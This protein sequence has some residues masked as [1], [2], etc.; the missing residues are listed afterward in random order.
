MR[1]NMGK[2]LLVFGISFFLGRYA[3]RDFFNA[4]SLVGGKTDFVE[5]VFNLQADFFKPPF[6]GF[7]RNVIG[8][9]YFAD[10]FGKGNRNHHLI[11][12][13]AND[14]GA[15]DAAR[16][17]KNRFAAFLGEVNG[18]FAQFHAWTLRSVGNNADGG[19]IPQGFEQIP[20]RADRVAVAGTADGAQSAFF[21]KTGNQTA[22]LV[23]GDQ[24]VERPLF[25]P[26]VG[27]EHGASVPADENNAAFFPPAVIEF[28]DAFGFPAGRSAD[29]ACIK[30]K[31][32]SDEAGNDSGFKK[33]FESLF[34]YF[35]FGHSVS[36]RNAELTVR[37]F[38]GVG[39]RN[40]DGFVFGNDD[41][42][43]TD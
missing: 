24:R 8:A 28:A 43:V 31:E 35:C 25:V 20:R 18:T 13:F 39:N 17:A 42:A 1:M 22:V 14:F 40:A 2:T 30:V 37:F 3:R 32:A 10:A 41:F 6:I 27:I 12:G 33:L 16:N 34:Q 26:E 21:Q 4:H 19:V 11:P 36:V 23:Q 7:G 38:D 15:F 29:E 9:D 5:F